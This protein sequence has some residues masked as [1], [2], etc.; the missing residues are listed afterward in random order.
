MTAADSALPIFV[1]ILGL[2]LGSFGNVLIARIPKGVSISGRSHCPQCK[3][4]LAAW[5]LVPVL[6]Y[7]CLGGRCRRCR[8]FISVQYP[9][10]E[11]ACGLLF[12]F[13]FVRFGVT[14]A[15]GVLALA[16]WLLLLIAV[17]DLRTRTIPDVFN[18]PFILLAVT[19][20]LLA[21]HFSA[22]GALVMLL[23][24]GGQWLLSRGRWVGS[25]DILLG[26]GIGFLLGG[27]ACA[28][29]CL[30]LAYILGSIVALILLATKLATRKSH[31]PF[32]PFLAAAALITLVVGE[33]ILTVILPGM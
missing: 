2:T 23:F 21:R 13:A 29:L 32:G 4:A 31:I 26:I 3:K 6:S 16:L 9:L 30:A 11:I 17:T 7:I 15:A 14:P 10:V 12:L 19:Y 18:L 27:I 33:S 28:L 24:F 20:A 1:F 8:K 22:A 5:E 25:G